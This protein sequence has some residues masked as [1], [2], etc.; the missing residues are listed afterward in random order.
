MVP[1]GVTANVAVIPAALGPGGFQAPSGPGEG[2]ANSV[3]LAQAPQQAPQGGGPAAPAT[4]SAPVP[5]V[6][7]GPAQG[8][9]IVVQGVVR[10]LEMLQAVRERHRETDDADTDSAVKL[11]V[12][13]EPGPAEAELVPGARNR[14][15]PA[16]DKFEVTLAALSEVNDYAIQMHLAV[17][18]ASSAL[19]TIKTLTERTG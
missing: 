17:N 13:R 9:N 10:Y 1:G 2:P 8:R 14:V 18:V 11:V 15:V 5:E 12:A 7:V 6:G 3:I 4:T 19:G 16:T